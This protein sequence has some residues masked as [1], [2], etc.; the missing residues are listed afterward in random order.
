MIEM[1]T[2]FGFPVAVCVYLL[3]THTKTI[4]ELS[5]TQSESMKNMTIAIEKLTILIKERC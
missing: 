1:I 4:S 5:K 2:T 3:H